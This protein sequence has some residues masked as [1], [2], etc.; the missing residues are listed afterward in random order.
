[1]CFTS[2]YCQSGG[3]IGVLSHFNGCLCTSLNW[4]SSILDSGIYANMSNVFNQ[5]TCLVKTV[6]L[7][8]IFTM[9]TVRRFLSAMQETRD[10]LLLISSF[11]VFQMLPVQ[12][13]ALA[14]TFPS[15]YLFLCHHRVNFSLEGVHVRQNILP[16]SCIR[17]C[18]ASSVVILR[19]LFGNRH[20]LHRTWHGGPSVRIKA[21]PN[22]FAACP[23][24]RRDFNGRP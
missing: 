21:G 22:V 16:S 20:P 15:S 8:I 19:R 14:A 1:M 9:T 3:I 5:Y 11:V 24:R 7:R 23:P 2:N 18:C 12:I 10:V 13:C 17:I 4:R 6:L